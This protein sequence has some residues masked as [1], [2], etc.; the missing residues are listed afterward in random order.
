MV[1]SDTLVFAAVLHS[2]DDES[3]AIEFTEAV[4]NLPDRHRLLDHL[5]DTIR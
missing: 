4:A 1:A 3:E 2:P 5:Q